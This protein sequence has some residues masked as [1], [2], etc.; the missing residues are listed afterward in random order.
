M[1][2]VLLKISRGVR[3]TIKVRATPVD[4]IQGG[5][6]TSTNMNMNEVIANRGLELMGHRKG[7]YHFLH[8]NNDVNMSQSTNDVYPT[9]CRLAI[10]FS[11]DPLIESVRHLMAAI[12]AKAKEFQNVL[13]LGRTQ[14]QDAVPL[15]SFD[16][17]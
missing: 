7:E 4:L 11:D 17:E 9:A 12:E 5:A 15:V 16:G 10:L 1:V 2:H 6:G 14:L 13:K 8:P 3:V